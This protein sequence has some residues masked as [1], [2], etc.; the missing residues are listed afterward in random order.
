MQRKPPPPRPRPPH[1]SQA[2]RGRGSTINPVG[3]FERLDVEP[4]DENRDP[5]EEPSSPETLYLRDSSKSAL[6]S[7]DS[8]D[9]GFNFSLNPYR[10]CL[11]GCSYCQVG[12]TRVLMADGS[13]REIAALEVGDEIFGTKRIGAYRRYSK[14]LVLAHWETRKAGYRVVLEDGTEIVASADHR[15]LTDRGWKYVAPAARPEQRP[16]LTTNNKLMGFGGSVRAPARACD[17]ESYRRGYLS[18]MIRGDGY[19]A[20]GRYPREGRTPARSFQFR[21]ALTDTEALS[22]TATYLLDY[23]VNTTPFLF[24]E[25]TE[26]RKEAR[27]IRASSRA[28]FFTIQELIT[29]PHP[30]LLHWSRGFLAGLFDAEG[31]YHGGALRICNT[32]DR[33]LGRAK[34]CLTALG[35][36]FSDEIQHRANGKHLH[37]VRVT[38]GLSEHLRFFQAT[39]P[40][41][42][43]K[44]Q[45][46]GQAVKSQARLGIVAIEPLG[47]ELPMYD[48][49]TGTEDFIANGVISHNC[50]AR[51]THEYLGFSPGLDFETR[52][53]V[54]AG[55][56]RW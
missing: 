7:N 47:R 48:I 39:S 23:G 5:E 28:A 37:G 40:A 19:L 14:T 52:I 4:D 31:S 10:G 12:E 1:Q 43:R 2:H 36:A 51:P 20:A 53:L 55:C 13:A 44:H 24:Q 49:T 18:G 6:A 45:I 56:R 26:T 50:Y 41:I 22:R 8:P 3:R 29:W 46:E 32:D 30:R 54:K 9:I 15:F 17:N 21:L 25:A 38:G 33:I 27:A 11:H 35:F 34:H 42:I 16:Y